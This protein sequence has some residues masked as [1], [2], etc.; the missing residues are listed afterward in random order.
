MKFIVVGESRVAMMSTMMGS[1]RDIFASAV[2]VSASRK[3][4]Q[5]MDLMG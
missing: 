2:Q 4:V 5:N 3:F 1:K